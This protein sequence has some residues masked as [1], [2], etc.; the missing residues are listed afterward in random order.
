MAD[1]LYEKNKAQMQAENRIYQDQYAIGNKYLNSARGVGRETAA[2]MYQGAVNSGMVGPAPVN[3]YNSKY[4]IY[5]GSATP[6]PNA[7]LFRATNRANLQSRGI[8]PGEVEQSWNK[9]MAN[10]Y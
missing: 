7:A 4:N 3:M 5:G 1:R 8:N 9:F 2:N 6:S 10:N